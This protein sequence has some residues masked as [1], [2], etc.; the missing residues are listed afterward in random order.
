MTGDAAGLRDLTCGMLVDPADA[1]AVEYQ[2]Q[3]FYF[4][5]AHCARTFRLD[6]A[7]FVRHPAA[8]NPHNFPRRD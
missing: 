2:G 5:S 8:P 6:P 7:K 3:T 4:C 1:P